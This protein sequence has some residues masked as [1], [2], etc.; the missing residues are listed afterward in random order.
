MSKTNSESKSFLTTYATK[1][2]EITIYAKS[3]C[4]DKYLSMT[5]LDLE[6]CATGNAAVVMEYDS[7]A[8]FLL[9]IEDEKLGDIIAEVE[10]EEIAQMVGISKCKQTRLPM[11][12]SHE[13]QMMDVFKWAQKLQDDEYFRIG[14]D[15]NNLYFFEKGYSIRFV[16]AI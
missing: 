13:Y 8:P 1:D 6:Y 3:N 7:D 9:K 4:N 16:L 2:N 15:E 10:Y 12:K 5:D 11:E 14:R